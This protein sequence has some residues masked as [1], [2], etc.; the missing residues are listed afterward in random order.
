VLNVWGDIDQYEAKRAHLRT[1]GASE[2][3]GIGGAV[4]RV[5]Q[6]AIGEQRVV[7]HDRRRQMMAHSFERVFFA[8]PSCYC[9]FKSKCNIVYL[10]HH[11]CY[12]R[13][14]Q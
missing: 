6:Y 1:S 7:R 9:N 11:Q 2:M 10:E 3:T 5:G 13:C 14:I 12:H 4:E 8:Q